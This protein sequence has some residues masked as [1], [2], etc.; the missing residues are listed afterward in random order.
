MESKD[1]LLK[2]IIK[3]SGLTITALAI[4]LKVARPTLHTWISGKHKVRGRAYID[5][6]RK[7]AKKYGIEE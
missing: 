1:M 6:I 3:K 5:N 4:E 2:K 7:I